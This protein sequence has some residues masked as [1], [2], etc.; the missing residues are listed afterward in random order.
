[1]RYFLLFIF[2]SSIILFAQK[3]KV[4]VHVVA[5]LV[6]KS[7]SGVYSGLAIDMWSHIAHENE[8]NYEIL[9]IPENSD[10][11]NQYDIVLTHPLTPTQQVEERLTQHYLTAKLGLVSRGS[12]SMGKVFQ[13]FKT[14]QFY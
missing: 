4:G 13:L 3:L 9:P 12:S 7:D 14:W 8:L 5:P 11:E 2:Y 1:M 6:E 10:Q